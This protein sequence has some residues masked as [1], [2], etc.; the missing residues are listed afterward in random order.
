LFPFLAHLKE[1]GGWFILVHSIDEGKVTYSD[2]WHQ[3]LVLG[4][5]ELLK[6]WDGIALHAEKKENSG[7]KT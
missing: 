7:E 6:R 1:K 4:E 2:G 3:N 5:D